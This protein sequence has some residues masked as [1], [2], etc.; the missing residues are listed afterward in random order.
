MQLFLEPSCQGSHLLGQDK[1]DSAGSCPLVPSICLQPQPLN[2][3][4]AQ[5]SWASCQMF[6][7]R[8]LPLE[9]GQHLQILTASQVGGHVLKHFYL[10]DGFPAGEVNDQHPVA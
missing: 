4:P 6:P 3:Q 9:P 7:N 1:L 8:G 2:I 5:P 10:F